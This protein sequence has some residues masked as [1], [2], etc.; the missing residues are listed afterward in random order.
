VVH[1]FTEVALKAHCRRRPRV[2]T[3]IDPRAGGALAP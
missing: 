1:P 2:A 3:G